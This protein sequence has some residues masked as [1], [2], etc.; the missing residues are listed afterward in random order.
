MA[1]IVGD[2]MTMALQCVTPCSAM[3]EGP[4]A[5]DPFSRFAPFP[6]LLAMLLHC[7]GWPK[8]GSA[9]VRAVIEGMKLSAGTP[10]SLWQSCMAALSDQ[11]PSAILQDAL[12][13]EAF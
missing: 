6:A 7:P 4:A 10:H 11:L 2:A 5:V 1:A 13:Q 9:L 8:M 3:R 12:E